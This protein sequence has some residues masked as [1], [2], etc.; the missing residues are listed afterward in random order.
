M[1]HFWEIFYTFA[2][3]RAITVIY[4]FKCTEPFTTAVLGLSMDYFNKFFPVLWT[5]LA[6]IMQIYKLFKN[7]KLLGM[8]KGLQLAL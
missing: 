1:Y 4:A 6:L 5:N 3:A 2:I 8:W 7:K